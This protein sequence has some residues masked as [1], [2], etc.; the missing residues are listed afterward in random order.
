MHIYNDFQ[1]ADIL[2]YKIGGRTKYLLEVQNTEDVLTAIGFIQNNDIKK[3]FV[4]GLG[5]NLLFTDDYFDGAVIRFIPSQNPAIV[6]R[7][8]NGV[9]EVFAGET[10]DRVI[11]FAF[12][13]NLIGLEWAGGLPGTIGAGVRG[14]VGAFGGEIKN[15]TNCVEVVDWTTGSISI[16]DNQELN[17]TYR[18]SAVKKNRNFIICSVVLQLTP[19][20]KEQVIEAKRIYQANID[21]RNKNH[22]HEY[23]NTG[24]TFKNIAT[25][26]DVEK[27]VQVFPDMQELI[28]TK[29]YGKVS[30]GYLNK[31]LGFSGRRVGNAQVSEQH[32][33][34]IN[35]LGGAKAKDVL[36]IIKEI[37]NK[38]QET[39]G[40]IPETEV[41]IVQ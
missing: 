39:F 18:S 31:R 1:L 34:F 35:N 24:S 10:L 23:P 3:I 9:I 22:P 41:E 33:N 11:Q 40:F 28:N 6:K 15:S 27:I 7:E 36:E 2:W 13:N 12:G 8:E 19:A 17:F 14:N 5:A 25:K 20:T 16:L 21:Y 29:W 32:A 37:Q 4:C 30:M 38:F 26:E